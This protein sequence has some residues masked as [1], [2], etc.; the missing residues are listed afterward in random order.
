MD[1]H[2]ADNDLAV[3]IFIVSRRKSM[4]KG[5][6]VFAVA[7]AA[8]ALGGLSCVV[9]CGDKG[10][11]E[12]V[13]MSAAKSASIIVTGYEWGPGVTGV[14]VEFDD[15]VKGVTK[16]TFTVKTANK[17]RTVQDAYC[18]DAKGVKSTEAT[19]YVTLQLGKPKVTSGM[20]GANVEA[21]PFS[22][23]MTKNVNNWAAEYKVNLVVAE[24]QS[25]T[26]GKVKYR[27]SDNYS[28]NVT[29]ADHRIVPQ[30]ATWDKDTYTYTGEGKNITL[31]RAAR[32]PDGADADNQKNPLIIWLHG[33]GEG[34][35][36]IDIDLLGNEV[37]GLTSDNETNV[38]HYFK[39]NGSAGAYVLAVQ[40]PTM[41]MDTTG[42]GGKP[43][44]GESGSQVSYYTEALYGAITDYVTKTPDIDTNRIYIGGCS[45]GGYMTMN[46]MFEHGDYFTAF[47]PICEAYRDRVYE[48]D[49]T[50][51]KH[52]NITDDM[53]EQIKD[54]KIWFLQS[55][56]D[57]TVNPDLYMRPT[58]KRLLDAG[59]QNV[60]AT[61]TEKV[62][63]KD[64]EGV[65]Y[66]GH[67]SWIYAFNDDVKKRIDNTA[68]T[69]ASDVN[70]TK[71]TV[72]ANMWD[73]LSKQ[74]KA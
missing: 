7:M 17:A 46:M 26:V 56:N 41:W 22:Y 20:W 61:M 3:V 43:N 36:D 58:F 8:A 40:T 70:H 45:N 49:N 4:K 9:A 47:Y 59:A 39:A 21:S 55:D 64:A 23:D 44:D 67:W 14:V 31:T 5:K 38:Q 69:S 73:W 65:N 54:Y 32:K 16:D 19:K 30:T 11:H 42:E 57:G 2:F 35:T 27:A 33:M 68:I 25:F 63:G 37:T 6:K 51:V 10:P 66:D 28:Y 15:V 60:F 72:E 13:E 53:I 50:T 62:T 24:K 52:L 71:C 74:T 29:T 12:P 34:G 18:S 1:Y 48:A